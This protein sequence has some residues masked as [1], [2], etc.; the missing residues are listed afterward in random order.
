MIALEAAL[1]AEN[2]QERGYIETLFV[3]VSHFELLD[4][5]I[6]GVRSISAYCFDF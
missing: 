6:P 5:K 1:H 4:G 2:A 3:I